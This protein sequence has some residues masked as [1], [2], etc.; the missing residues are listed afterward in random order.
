MMP[1]VRILPLEVGEPMI[2]MEKASKSENHEVG[3]IHG[4]AR[5]L[6]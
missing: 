6:P 4:D 2:G 5:Q 3:H 1:F